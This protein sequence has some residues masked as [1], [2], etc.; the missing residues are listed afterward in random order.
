[1]LPLV[2]STISE[3]PRSIWPSAS[4]AS[5]IATPMRSLT[6]PPGLK[7]SSLAQT[8]AP[9]PSPRR[10]R[11]TIGVLPTTSPASRPI[12]VAAPASV[13]GV[14]DIAPKLQPAADPRAWRRSIAAPAASPPVR[15]AAQSVFFGAG[16]V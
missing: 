13:G 12:R 16:L 15:G 9:T 1:V 5:I 14:T 10:S 6:D 8:S 11:A 2:G 3:E 4:A 7:Y